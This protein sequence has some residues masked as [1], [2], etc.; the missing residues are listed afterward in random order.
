M[1]LEILLISL[2][3]TNVISINETESEIAE[4]KDKSYQ[5]VMYFDYVCC[6][7]TCPYCGW[8]SGKSK[9]YT[10]LLMDPTYQQFY[11]DCC[12]EVIYKNNMT[13]SKEISAPC[14]LDDTYLNDFERF[15]KFFKTGPIYLI[16]IVAIILF[17]VG[18]FIL[19]ACCIFG[20]KQPPLDY[21]F[22]VN[23]LNDE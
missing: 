6:K 22:I 16:V 3:V 1:K 5:C 9:N 10:A 4:S 14:V 17:L 23:S 11:S 7:A 2:F 13:C 18:A 20:K 19:Y 12:A 15:V 8:C 21:K